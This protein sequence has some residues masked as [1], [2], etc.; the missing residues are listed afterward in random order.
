MAS[1]REKESSRIKGEIVLRAV[2]IR[3]GDRFRICAHTYKLQTELLTLFRMFFVV[4][5]L[6][7]VRESKRAAEISPVGEISR[8]LLHTHA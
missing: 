6:E 3:S 2:R 4:L 5:L 8:I 7:R 1:E